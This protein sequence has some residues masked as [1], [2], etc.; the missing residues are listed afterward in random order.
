MLLMLAGS[1]RSVRSR[2]QDD[3]QILG[4]RYF[5]TLERRTPLAYMEMERAFSAG[6]KEPPLVGPSENFLEGG[7]GF[8]TYGMWLRE[9]D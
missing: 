1:S 2:N 7:A 6:P 4:W 8:N 3:D 5:A 9:I